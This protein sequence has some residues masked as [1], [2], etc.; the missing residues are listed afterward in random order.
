MF[1]YTS[2]EKTLGREEDVVS[3]SVCLISCQ[4]FIFSGEV[5]KKILEGIEPMIN[6]TAPPNIKNK[7]QLYVY[8]KKS[9]SGEKISMIIVKISNL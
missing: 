6:R 5:K 4:V 8:L 2:A 7:I 3:V 1:L 9:V